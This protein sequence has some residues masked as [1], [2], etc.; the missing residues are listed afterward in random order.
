MTEIYRAGRQLIKVRIVMLASLPVAA[1]L[2]WWGWDIFSTYGLRP[3]DGGVLAPLGIRLAFGGFVALLG[4]AIAFGLWLYSTVCVAAL[5]HDP[6]TGR[7]HLRTP[8]YVGMREDGFFAT[9]VRGARYYR[10]SVYAPGGASVRAPWTTVRVA[11]RSLPYVFDGQGTWRDFPEAR[12]LL[13]LPEETAR[14][15]QDSWG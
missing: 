12:R 14:A 4:L 7:L 13:G 2:C 1:A 9:E 5:D 8:G 15:R 3:A 10:G 11:G 6:R